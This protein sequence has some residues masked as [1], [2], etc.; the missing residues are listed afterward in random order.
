MGFIQNGTAFMTYP[1]MK[2]IAE[3]K[4]ICMDM[5]HFNF[6]LLSPGE[7][8][9]AIDWSITNHFKDTPVVV[10]NNYTHKQINSTLS[11]M[12]NYIMD[13][14][15]I[16]T[17]YGVL[18]KRH[19]TVPNP[20][21]GMIDGF[22]NDRKAMKKEMFKYP[23]GSEDFEKYNLLQL[24][25]K[26]DA[27]GFYGA[28][29]LYSCIFYNL[30]TASSVTTQGRSCNSA[31]ALFLES[32]LNNNVP[33]SSMNE[34]I[35]FIH[36]V[37]NEEHH[38]DSSEI[39][40]IHASLEETFFQLLSST[41]Y[42]WIP[43]EDEMHIV[44]EILSKLSQDELDRLFYK[45]N[46]Y[47]FIDNQAVSQAILFILQSLESPF[48]DPNEPPENI[49]EPLKAL[50]DILYEYVYYNKQIIDRLAKM[51]SLVRS[52]SIIQDTD[53][54][55]VSFDGF[56]QYVRQMCHGIPMKIKTQNVD[57]ATYL[58][59][60]E[61]KTEPV[62]GKITEYSF[63]DDDM[64]EMDRLVDPMVI[65]PQDG[66]RYSIINLLAYCVGILLNDYMDRY[67]KNSHSENER[68]CLITMKNEF[69]FKRVL[70]SS[71]AKKHYAYKVEL[72]E[73]NQ[74]PDAKSIDAKGM[75]VFVKSTVNPTIQANLRRILAEDILNVESVDPIAV[76]RA[77]AKEEKKIYQSIQQGE[78]KFFKPLKVKSISA[79]ENPMRIQGI[80]ASQVYNYLHEPGT[81]ALDMSIRNSVDVAKVEIN[82]KNID[83]IRDSH[84]YVYEKALE[85]M[86]QPE[87]A[88]RIDAV[89]I[90]LNEPVPT[91][92]LPF[93]NYD[94]IINNNLKG[95][96]IE[97]IG[98]YRGSATN[99][100]TNMIQF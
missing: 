5:L 8:S 6:P 80:K 88:T 4:R 64:I 69:L 54:A 96:P 56:Y 84:P 41:G 99:N 94:E 50:T 63:V 53:S 38:Y 46:L 26:I 67:C 74:V 16:I 12:A 19:G 55:I 22:I 70:L 29:G 77:L 98:I 1:D 14:E 68:A 87:Y 86:K 31:A 23:K 21:Y 35:E 15:P 43:S 3:Y 89:A 51:D 82:P 42:G 45:N 73:G 13:K 100:A 81:E 76:L 93:V 27:N 90:P 28:T 32:F 44:W 20:L 39:I 61:V 10:D 25:L 2:A 62:I 79:Y 83:R 58:D 91:W 49:I 37:L 85:L 34:L 71:H 18:F 33:M 78:K 65:I 36:S 11:Y 7:L 48:M 57:A 92:I 72:Q 97:S 24:L 59:D 30:Y 17:S 52:V 47:H 9:A 66:L 75:E 60:G 40:D 95:F